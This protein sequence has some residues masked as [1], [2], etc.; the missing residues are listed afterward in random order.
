MRYVVFLLWLTLSPPLLAEDR[1]LSPP[2]DIAI[3]EDG[4][5]LYLA[6]ATDDSIQLFD[7]EK[8]KVFSHFK[9]E[10]VRE[11]ALS[12]EETKCSCQAFVEPLKNG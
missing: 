10:G 8:E 9:A 12:H 1:Y 2:Y 6:C 4:S 7:V 3:S 5:V 11:I